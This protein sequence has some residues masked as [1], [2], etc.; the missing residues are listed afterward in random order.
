MGGQRASRRISAAEG[1]RFTARAAGKSVSAAPAPAPSRH[2]RPAMGV[3]L[4]HVGREAVASVPRAFPDIPT[5]AE[6]GVPKYD[7]DTWYGMFGPASLPRPMVTWLNQTMN[8]VLNEP[9]MRQRL[10]ET[11][12]EV[13]T[14]TPEALQKVVVEDIA[15]WGRI[16]RTANIRID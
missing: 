2:D 7:Y 8:R 3:E 15:R 10:S 11:G 14:G 5:I 9:A 12:L 16:I 4:R 6:S 13:E 1:R